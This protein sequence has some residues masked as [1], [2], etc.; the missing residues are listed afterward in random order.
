MALVTFV[1]DTVANRKKAVAYPGYFKFN[2]TVS[3]APK[4]TFT[5]GMTIDSA[6]EIEAWVDGRIQQEGV[7][8]NRNTGAGTVIFTGSVGVGSWVYVKVYR[9]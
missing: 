9:K 4:T 7:A 5:L 3:D 2:E 8:W 1:H 6:H